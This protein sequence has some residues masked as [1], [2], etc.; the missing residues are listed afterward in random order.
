MAHS[1]GGPEAWATWSAFTFPGSKFFA[2]VVIRLTV[3]SNGAVAPRMKRSGFTRAT[4]K[5][6][7]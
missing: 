2:E 1:A 6:L 5:F 7:R 4:T 3:A